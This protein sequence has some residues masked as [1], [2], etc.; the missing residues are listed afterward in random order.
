MASIQKL[1]THKTMVYPMD[2]FINVRYHNTDVVS[3]NDE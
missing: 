3:F 1:G 2:N